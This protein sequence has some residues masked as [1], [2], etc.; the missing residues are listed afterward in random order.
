MYGGLSAS[1]GLVESVDEL[2]SLRA[3][4]VRMPQSRGLIKVGDRITVVA[5]SID[6][7]G[8]VTVRLNGTPAGTPSKG[9]GGRRGPEGGPASH[10][11]RPPPHPRSSSR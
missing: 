3:W 9:P 7:R 6:Q 10:R 8:K 2:P 5:Q 4:T 1:V 11:S